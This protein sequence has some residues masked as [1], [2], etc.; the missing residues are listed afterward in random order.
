MAG[1]TPSNAIPVHRTSHIPN[2]CIS[3]LF[4]SP[5]TLSFRSDQ[6]GSLYSLGGN[7][8]QWV[9]LVGKDNPGDPASDDSTIRAGYTYY[10]DPSKFY[11]DGLVNGDITRVVVRGTGAL[12]VINGVAI[13]NNDA[14]E[15][16]KVGSTLTRVNFGL[17]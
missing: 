17:D 6:D 9:T 3:E 16:H 7:A 2:G 15:L 11:D 13:N 8:S 12:V 14:V 10:V 1:L 5:G 4:S